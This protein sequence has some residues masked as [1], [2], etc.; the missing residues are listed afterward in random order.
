MKVSSILVLLILSTTVNATF[1]LQP[2]ITPVM[3]TLGALFTANEIDV[4]PLLDGMRDL[5]SLKN[6]NVNKMSEEKEEEESVEDMLGSVSNEDFTPKDD[7]EKE[8]IKLDKDEKKV[9]ESEG[10]KKGLAEVNAASEATR[11]ELE[12]SHPE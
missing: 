10:Y 9:R 8:Q 11:K 5:L 7:V 12:K 6:S 2:L 3:F 4:D 1:L